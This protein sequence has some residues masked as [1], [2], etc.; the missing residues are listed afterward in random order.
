MSKSIQHSLYFK[1]KPE[2]VWEYL[3]RSELMELWLM[4][5]DFQP[6]VGADFQFK[7]KSMPDL[8]FDG[9]FYCKVLTCNP[10]EN[11]SYSWKMGPGDGKIDIDSVV[12]WTLV[13]KEEGTE[14]RLLHSGFKE[15]ANLTLYSMMNDGWLSNMHKI[16]NRLNSETSATV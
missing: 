9:I 8:D 1:Q 13:P 3:T 6:I 10:Y 12:Q 16:L 14:L 4:K 15:A 2:Q 7:A 11:L 5:N